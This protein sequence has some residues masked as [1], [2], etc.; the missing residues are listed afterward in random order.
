M[1]PF[2][3][4]FISM[5]I[6]ILLSYILAHFFG[7]LGLALGFSISAYIQLVLLYLLL[8][9]HIGAF[10]WKQI[11]NPFGKVF[12]ATLGFTFIA[13]YGKTFFEP[14]AKDGTTIGLLTQTL[15]ATLCGLIV[16]IFISIIVKN[17]EFY[18]F[19]DALK[20]KLLKQSDI[21]QESIEG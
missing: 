4:S 3:V 8:H 12:L 19:V 9:V 18:A 11:V 7:V 14:F 17:E 1:R 20:K 6:N 13:Q 2:V 15:L 21:P 5:L 16:F 10:D